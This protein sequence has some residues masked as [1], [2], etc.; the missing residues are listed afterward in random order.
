M[1]PEADMYPEFYGA[2][3]DLSQPDECPDRQPITVP[4]RDSAG[5]VTY[6]PACA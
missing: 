2:P 3:V 5:E 4:G 1:P 6:E